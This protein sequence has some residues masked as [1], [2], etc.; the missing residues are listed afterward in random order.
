MICI[1]TI[2]DG[3]FSFQIFG[4]S[5]T[6]PWLKV[7]NCL[8]T[9]LEQD[10]MAWASLTQKFY[11]YQHKRCICKGC[12]F[13]QKKL[14]LIF[15]ISI[16]HCS[17]LSNQYRGKS[18]DFLFFF[19]S[20]YLLK[21]I[22]GSSLGKWPFFLNPSLLT[23]Y[24][25]KRKINQVLKGITLSAELTVFIWHTKIFFSHC[26]DYRKQYQCLHAKFLIALL[27]DEKI[28]DSIKEELKTSHVLD[29][30]KDIFFLITTDMFYRVL[31]SQMK[32]LSIWYA[33]WLFIN[34]DC[35]SEWIREGENL[36]WQMLLCKIE[37]GENEHRV[38][39]IERAALAHANENASV[40]AK[41]SLTEII[42]CTHNYKV[43]VS[44]WCTAV[45]LRSSYPKTC[46]VMLPELEACPDTEV[47]G[48][49]LFTSLNSVPEISLCFTSCSLQ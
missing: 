4:S 14:L 24:N 43:Y 6:K 9:L 38:F 22:I 26:Q 37:P 27:Q 10:L 45:C 25:C 15:R 17:S 16:Y 39:S 19:Q 41:D 36:T 8:T 48:E 35:T 42:F 2:K 44:S 40:I 13:T 31:D 11:A 29:Q 30:M 23:E 3:E 7:S 32:T 47:Q 18:A 5:N 49:A 20:R 33:S 12:M 21:E 46:Y 28:E 34:K 1:L